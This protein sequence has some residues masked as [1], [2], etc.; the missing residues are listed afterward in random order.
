[1][2]PCR[3]NHRAPRSGEFDMRCNFLA[4]NSRRNGAGQP[5]TDITPAAY[6]LRLAA[7]ALVIALT[8][9]A[10]RPEPAL[11]LATLPAAGASSINLLIATT[12]RPSD[13]P[14][15]RFGGE[16]TLTTRFASM[17]VSIP[18]RHQSGDIAW[19]QGGAPDAANA[20]AATRFETIPRESIRAALQDSIRQSRSSHVLVFVHGYNTRFDEAAFRLA[21]IVHDSGAPVTPVLFSWPSWGSL[22]SYPYDRE[23]AAISR[24]GL[25][26]VLTALSRE[27]GV[28]QVSIL[29]HSMG[30]W[31]TL[32]ALRQM[33]IRN[34]QIFPKITDIMLA[35]PDVD[36]DVASAQGRVIQSVP[37]KARITLFVSGD[38]KALNASRFLWGS[39]DRLGSLDPKAEPYR[40]NLAKSGVEVIDLTSTDGGD[41]LNHGKFATSPT[42]VRLIGTRLASGQRLHGESSLGERAGAVTQ[43]TVKI[44]GDVVTS[45]LRIGTQN[46][47]LNEPVSEKG[48]E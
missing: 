20:F 30:G 36:V 9:C 34:R 8:G 22:S 40:T 42:V 41:S 17:T 47:L 24:D 7:T 1:M 14:G 15:I 37:K 13:D 21:Q 46:P 3:F 19:P 18:A 26:T 29:A 28:S 23:S 6:A 11:K 35:A 16:R 43:G 38:D 31:L 4:T 25:E 12:R 39:R 48:I 44:L 2:V 5:R 45:P 27:P 10:S 33:A 32:E